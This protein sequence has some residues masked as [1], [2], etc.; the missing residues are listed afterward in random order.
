VP[1]RNR[2][3]N[4]CEKPLKNVMAKCP[5]LTETF[6]RPDMVSFRKRLGM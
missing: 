5:I 2:I 3:F 4:E 1:E 6:D